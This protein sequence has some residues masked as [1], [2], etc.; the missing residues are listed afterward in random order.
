MRGVLFGVVAQRVREFGAGIV[1]LVGVLARRLRDHALQ[2]LAQVRPD[3][4]DRHDAVL[5]RVGTG[6]QIEQRGAQR[7]DVGALVDRAVLGELFGGAEA[8]RA[9][10]TVVANERTLALADL[11]RDTEV[12]ELDRAVGR[13]H[14]VR[15]LHVAKDD[16]RLATVQVVEHVAQLDTPVDDVL[17]LL[18]SFLLEQA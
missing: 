16:W 3:L 10:L 8:R 2:A 15:R 17:L 5:A 12:D 11:Q 1:A 13:E 4:T 9:E 18:R 14:H 7:V 6:E